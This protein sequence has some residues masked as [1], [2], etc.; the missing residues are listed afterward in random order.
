MIPFSFLR[1]PT[2]SSYQHITPFSDLMSDFYSS[3]VSSF[4][5]PLANLFF[6][7]WFVNFN[8]AIFNSL[9]IYPLDGGQ[10]LLILIRSFKK[11]SISEKLAYNITIF[12]TFIFV[13]IV[14]ILLLIPYVSIL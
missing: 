4:F 12:I 9:P 11:N 1:V 13:S 6:W 8:L 7:I 3:P 5:K 10:S 2:M 14:A